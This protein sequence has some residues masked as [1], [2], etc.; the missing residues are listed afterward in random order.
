LTWTFG[1]L[2]WLINTLLGVPQLPAFIVRRLL[3]AHPI[4]APSQSASELAHFKY[5]TVYGMVVLVL[6]VWVTETSRYRISTN[7]KVAEAKR[8]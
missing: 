7:S 5:V 1:L 4:G 3:R 6:A 8:M 2:L